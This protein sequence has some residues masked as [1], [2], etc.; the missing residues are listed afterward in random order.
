[1]KRLM[2]AL[3]KELLSIKVNAGESGCVLTEKKWFVYA[4]R[5][6]DTIKK[7]SFISEYSRLMT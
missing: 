2:K 3:S 4:N 1:M 6:W 5:V 7:S